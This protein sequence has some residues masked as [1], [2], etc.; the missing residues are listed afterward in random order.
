M[1]TIY[2][3][4]RDSCTHLKESCKILTSLASI[5]LLIISACKGLEYS[6]RIQELLMIDVQVLCILFLFLESLNY[7]LTVPIQPPPNPTSQ[8]SPQMKILGVGCRAGN[9]SCSAQISQWT[10][11]TDFLQEDPND[12]CEDESLKYVVY[13]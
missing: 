2:G 5:V 9:E 7:V 10:A 13:G 12:T 4:H 3:A 6:Y 8:V 1:C 11:S